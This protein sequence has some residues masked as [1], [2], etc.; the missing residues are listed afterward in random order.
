MHLEVFSEGSSPIHRLDPRVKIIVFTIFSIL[1]AT[2]T[3]L[4]TP[5]LYLSYS[6]CLILLARV[7]LRPFLSRLFLAN[8]FILFIWIFIPLFYSGNTH[9]SI[10][11]LKISKEGVMYALSITLKCNGIII[12]T[13]AL[14]STSTVFSLAHALSHLKVPIK[15]IT[16]FFLFYRYI[17]VIHL[18]YLKI[19][20]AVLTRGFIARTNL[21]TY[22]TFAY[23]MAGLLIKSYER[24]E[25]IYR[26]MLCRGF[27]GYFPLFEHF[28]IRKSDIIFFIVANSISIY[29]WI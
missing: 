24:A 21:H 9:Y 12:A 1:C 19:K 15:L 25:E 4:K 23:I 10:G 27:K 26:A 20:R 29:F 16:I 8:F 18:E 17:T 2:S 7:K 28:K 13:I 3:G 6:I 5:F 22:R 11:P 14:L